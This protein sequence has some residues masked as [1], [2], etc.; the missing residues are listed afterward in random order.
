MSMLE[1]KDYFVWHGAEGTKKYTLS[2]FE[3][4]TGFK[5]VLQV[6]EDSFLIAGFEKGSN[7]PTFT[8]RHAVE[9]L[10]PLFIWSKGLKSDT[11]EIAENNLGFPNI[12]LVKTYPCLVYPNDCH[13]KTVNN[14]RYVTDM[15]YICEDNSGCGDALFWR[16]VKGRQAIIPWLIDKL[17]DTTCTAVFV[18]NFGGYYTVADVAYVALQEIVAG[19]PTFKLLGVKFDQKGCG[20]CSYYRYL[21]KNIRNRKRFE[22]AVRKWYQQNREKLIWVEST[23]TLVCDCAALP[24]PNGGHYMVNNKNN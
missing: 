16:A 21:R 7:H 3:H 2:F 1:Q 22:K 5:G 23:E 8:Q 12:S 20:Y 17:D 4:T 10:P 13:Q 9:R 11:V 6:N 18:P 19:I 24:H 15:P 14:L